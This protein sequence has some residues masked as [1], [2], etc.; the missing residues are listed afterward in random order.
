MS[1]VLNNHTGL[2]GT[3]KLLKEFYKHVFLK[4]RD[5]FV[6]TRKKEIEA[7]TRLIEI[8]IKRKTGFCEH[9]DESLSSI[10]GGDVLKDTRDPQ[11]FYKQ[12]IIAW[13]SKCKPQNAETSIELQQCFNKSTP[14]F[15]GPVIKCFGSHRSETCRR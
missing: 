9:V 13:L 15:F 3:Q 8:R 12:Y 6:E 4:V 5:N 2:T 11:I 14:T 10:Q 1:E 7:R